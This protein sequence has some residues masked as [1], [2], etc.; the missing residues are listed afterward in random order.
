[1]GGWLVSRTMEKRG[2][3]SLSGAALPRP[4]QIGTGGGRSEQT[5]V[6]RRFPAHST[7]AKRCRWWMPRHHMHKAVG[8]Y[9]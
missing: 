8:A 2:M 5:G 6:Q 9:C 3:A 1:M 7:H 4:R